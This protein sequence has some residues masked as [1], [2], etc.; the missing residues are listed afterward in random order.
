MRNLNAD[1]IISNWTWRNTSTWDIY[2]DNIK[3]IMAKLCYDW[4]F[5]WLWKRAENLSVDNEWLYKTL[6]WYVNLYKKSWDKYI[7][8]ANVVPWYANLNKAQKYAEYM[9][10]SDVLTSILSSD[11]KDFY[12]NY[13][14]LDFDSL[15][16]SDTDKIMFIVAKYFEK[17]WCNVS[18]SSTT[19]GSNSFFAYPVNIFDAVKDNDFS[20]ENL[21]HFWDAV[22]IYQTKRWIPVDLHLWPQT[23]R[24]I[25]WDLKNE[26]KKYKKKHLDINNWWST[27]IST[28]TDVSNTQTDV[29]NT[30]TDVS[31]T[32]TDLKTD[33]RWVPLR[34]DIVNSTQTDVSNTQTDLKTDKRWVPLRFDIGNSTQTGGIYWYNLDKNYNFNDW[35]DSFDYTPYTDSME[36]NFL[37]NF[38]NTRKTEISS[39][40]NNYDFNRND[41]E[42][43]N[44][45]YEI[46]QKLWYEQYKKCIV[47][48]KNWLI[49]KD[50]KKNSSKKIQLTDQQINKVLSDWGF[51]VKINWKVVNFSLYTETMK[52]V[53]NKYVYKINDWIKNWDYDLSTP[54]IIQVN[55]TNTVRFSVLN[56]QSNVNNNWTNL[57]NRWIPYRF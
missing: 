47:Q 4:W 48:L 28:Q 35:S 44:K 51:S 18:L 39:I 25:A 56:Q 45:T 12:L 26:K 49:V 8:D 19:D 7:K 10:F 13:L 34:F 40:I 6:E 15:P 52:D 54:W 30:Q 38:W 20:S 3:K 57:D 31:N 41:I 46:L 17:I 37:G 16:G 43:Y 21:W 50:I 36:E 32:Q 29:S 11:N 27:M 14:W 23:L 33:K 22:A 1:I 2:P 55:K 42:T 24:A 5:A 9:G 53:Q